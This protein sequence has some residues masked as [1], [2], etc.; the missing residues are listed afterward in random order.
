MGSSRGLA[1]PARRDRSRVA[2]L[3]LLG[4]S[5][6][7]AA[8]YS[9]IGPVAPAVARQTG[10]GPAVVGVLVAAFP[11]GI[12]I[13]FITAGQAIR[14]HRYGLLLGVSLGLLA[15][16]SL[17]FVA[18]DGLPGYVAA[19]FVMG[20]GSGGLWMGITF[21]TL[22]RWPGQE[23]LCMSR[24]FAAYSV[25]GLLGPTIGAIG[26]IREP[27]LAY[28]VLILVGGGLVLALGP[29]PSRRSFVTDPSALRLPAFWTASAG[30]V[31]A[32]L[33]LGIVEGVLP[34]HFSADLSQTQIGIVLAGAAIVVA[35]AAILAARFAPRIALRSAMPAIVVGIGFAGIVAGPPG[36]MVGLAIGAIGIGLA[37]TGSI[38]VLLAGV[39][40]ER[41]I[42]AIVVWSQVGIVAYLIGPLVGGVAVE[43][44]GYG[45]LGVLLAVAA[46]PV[47]IL[48]SRPGVTA[49]RPA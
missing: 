5:V 4:L 11:G 16:G 35:A 36:W 31:F 28:F 10:V 18:V 27:F 2:Y 13:G 38:G 40:A 17:G 34:L 33:A 46:I 9:V 14:A 47:A 19:R 39:P 45:I 25:G 44:S 24:I 48:L 21:S 32:T 12:A 29:S 8:G 41:S 30:I 37:N 43:T 3:A 42:T 49:T 26:G 20:L 7:D 15:L 23:Y 6:I 22:E 1:V